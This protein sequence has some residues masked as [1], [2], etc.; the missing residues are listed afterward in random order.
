MGRRTKK[1]AGE[2]T[3]LYI[4]DQNGLLIAEYDGSGNWQKDYIYLNGQ[5]LAMIV[6]NT[7]ESIYYYQNDHLGTPQVMTGGI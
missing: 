5:P 6:A 4:Y 2:T 1:L 7:P 3:T